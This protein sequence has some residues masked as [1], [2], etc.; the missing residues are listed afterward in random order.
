MNVAAARPS[1]NRNL[2]FI[3]ALGL[4]GACL[5]PALV[6]AQSVEETLATAYSSNPTLL[7]ARARLRSVNEGVPQALSN[8]RPRVTVSGSGRPTESRRCRGGR[9]VTRRN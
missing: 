1:R 6:A 8:W 9:R 5:S 2:R 3:V 4:V 7:G